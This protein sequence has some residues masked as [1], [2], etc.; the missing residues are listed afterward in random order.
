M[1]KYIVA[2]WK[3]NK[4]LEEVKSW[5]D[6][7]LAQL[8]SLNPRLKV[9]LAVPFPFL[10]TVGQLLRA[11]RDKTQQIKL[12]VQDISPYPAGSYTGAVSVYNLQGLGVEYA[13]VGHSERRKYFSETNQTVAEKCQ[14]LV[15]S[16]IRPVLCV[17]AENAKQQ[18]ASLSD[19]IRDKVIVAYD[20]I[21]AISTHSAAGA[22]SSGEV[23]KVVAGIKQFFGQVPVIYGGSVD[24][25]NVKMYMLIC[26]GVLPGR[27]SLDAKQFLNLVS[28]AWVEEKN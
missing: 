10:E 5:L 18:A 13:I 4:T 28:I 26:D 22:K 1:Q 19:E 21:S 27:A 14:L 7:F 3:S 9:V 23:T 6:V 25:D 15:E 2:N 17:E 12:A 8:S 24:E 11:N 20:P 16:N